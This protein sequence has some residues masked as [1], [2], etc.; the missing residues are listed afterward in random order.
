MARVDMKW[1]GVY[2]SV[3]KMGCEMGGGKQRKAR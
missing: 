1:G 3:S 2:G